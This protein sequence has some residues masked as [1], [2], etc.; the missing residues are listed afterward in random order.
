MSFLCAGVVRSL[1]FGVNSFGTSTVSDTLPLGK[2][3]GTAVHCLIEGSEGLAHPSFGRGETELSKR[4]GGL[5][6][7]PRWQAQ[8]VEDFARVLHAVDSVDVT[9]SVV[10]TPLCL[11]LVDPTSFRS[12]RLA[13]KRRKHIEK[14]GVEFIP[15]EYRKLKYT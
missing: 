11:K 14:H 1:R 7:G 9:R 15:G 5:R 2:L 10:A 3:D 4:P 8:E 6:E 12:R 13:R